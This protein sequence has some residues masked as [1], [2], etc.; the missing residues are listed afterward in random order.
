MFSRSHEPSRL[1]RLAFRTISL[2]AGALSA[3]LNLTPQLIELD[4]VVPPMYDILSL[5]DC[6]GEAMLVPMLQALYMHD[7]VLFGRAQTECFNNLAQVRCELDGNNSEDTIKPTPKNRNTLDMLRIV[8]DTSE[9]RDISQVIF[10]DWLPLLTLGEAEAIEM[11]NRRSRHLR[12]ALFK[13]NVSMSPNR[14][15]NYLDMLDR[16]CAYIEQ[17]EAITVNVL[18]VRCFYVPVY[19]KSYAHIAISLEDTYTYLFAYYC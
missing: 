16:L 4:I 11:I 9:H 3:L 2:Q 8:S 5:A 17:C 10:N 6:E 13:D 14:E 18:H 7:C 12:R 19:V 15:H 1:Q